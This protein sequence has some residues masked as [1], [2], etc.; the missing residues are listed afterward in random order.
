MTPFTK[1]ILPSRPQIDTS[2]AIFLLKKFGEEK[3]PSLSSA[4]IEIWQALPAGETDAS[5]REKGILPLDT[6]GGAFDHHGRN[7][8]VT[9][10]ELVAKYLD[11]FDDPALSKMLALATRDDFEGKGTVSSDPLDRAFGIAGLLAALNKTL[12]GEPYTVVMTVLPLFAAHY[13]EESKRTKELPAEVEKKQREGKVETFVVRQRGKNLKV[14]LIESNNLSM[15][16]Y[17]RSRLGGA[18]DVVAQ[19]METGHLNILTRPTK[20]VDLRALAAL[21]RAEELLLA[22]R[23]ESSFDMKSL[24]R[25]GRID[26]VPNWYY[27]TATNSIQNG[28]AQ[29]GTTA[30]TAIPRESMRKVLETGLSEELWNPLRS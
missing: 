2:I 8:K 30:A 13:A 22:D 1:I 3:F 29:P 9:A 28:G 5:L 26:S 10:S 19:I 15:A 16:G 17:L 24:A 23:G 11:V 25:S 18:F 7:E 14:I 12:P 6:G 4:S 21:I 20:H 27:D